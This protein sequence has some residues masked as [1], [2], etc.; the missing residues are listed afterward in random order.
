MS[1]L[2][3]QFSTP[4]ALTITLASLASSTTGVGQ[5]GT[6]VD[7]TTDRFDLIYLIA[8]FRT[9]TSP[10]A[11]RSIFI[12]LIKGDGTRRTDGAG[13]TDAAFTRENARLLRVI[14]TDNT[15]D[16]DYEVDL[17]IAN[18]GREL[19]VAVVHDTGVA[20]NATAAEQRI[21][22]YGEHIESVA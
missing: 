10:T 5:Q 20:F 21:H 3:P 12:Y 7:N 8:K 17:T 11:D 1:T 2:R 19:T 22:W 6:I 9:G 13:A 15:S 14:P 4:A 18:P 16:K